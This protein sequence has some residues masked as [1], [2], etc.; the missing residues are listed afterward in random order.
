[1]ILIMMR[2][3]RNSDR[4]LRCIGG[5]REHNEL[6]II[7][8]MHCDNQVA[9]ASV[10]SGST[11]Y[12]SLVPLEEPSAGM[13]GLSTTLYKAWSQGDGEVSNTQETPLSRFT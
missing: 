9:N 5:E 11:T 6:I 8:M 4:R 2:M 10:S 7:M 12:H 1:M 13:R 3:K